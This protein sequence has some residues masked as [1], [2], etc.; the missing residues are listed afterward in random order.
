MSLPESALSPADVAAQLAELRRDDPPVHG[1]RVMA[2]VYDAGRED[3]GRAGREALAAFGEVNALDPLTFPS[4]ARLENDLV[5]WALDLVRGAPDAVGTVTSGGSETCILAVLAAREAWRTRGRSGRAT[6]IV[7]ETAHPA[8]IKAAHLLDMDVHVVPVERESMRLTSAAVASAIREVGDSAALVVVSAPTYPQG[9][10]DD[11]ESIASLSQD[12]GIACHVDGCIGGV[13]LGVARRM[14]LEVPAF[15]LSVPGVSSF[16]LDLHKYGF[17]P[18]GV[19]ILLFA[20]TT[21]RSGTYFAYSAWP[22]YPLVNTTLQSTKPAAPMAAAWATLA[23]LGTAGLDRAVTEALQATRHLADG[24]AGIPGIR[25]VG[26]PDATLIALT[27]DDV[28]PFRIAD[29]MRERDWVLQPQPSLGDL[30]RTLHLTVQPV[31]LATV[32]LFLTDL[33]AAT[34]AAARDDWASAPEDLEAAFADLPD[35]TSGAGLPPRMAEVHALIDGLPSNV[36]DPALGAIFG[37]LFTSR[38]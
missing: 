11:I 21:Y 36:R 24:I 18:K 1:G 12:A 34:E 22:G 27:G 35:L 23:V 28:D 13:V 7:A 37:A 29:Y 38:R 31:S 3:A 9:V 15:D 32:E 2:Y 8:F 14:G 25:V 5:A 16:G 10:V 19:S 6:I 4:V 20:D 33:R 30:P 17:S 26:H